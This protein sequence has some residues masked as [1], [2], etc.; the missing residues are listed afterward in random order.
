MWRGR[1]VLWRIWGRRGI[2]CWPQGGTW[3][4]LVSVGVGGRRCLLWRWRE[5]WKPFLEERYPSCSDLREWAEM[6]LK[7]DREKGFIERWALETLSAT[8]G[9]MSGFLCYLPWLICLPVC[10]TLLHYFVGESYYVAGLET[11]HYKNMGLGMIL[12]FFGSFESFWSEVHQVFRL[13][14]CMWF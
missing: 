5:R 3:G 10:F 7:C 14:T 8:R 4:W 13:N 11:S 12:N 2:V 1:R 6:A 9:T